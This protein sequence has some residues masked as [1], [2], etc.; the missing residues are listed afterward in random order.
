M[1]PM[2]T[3]GGIQPNDIKVVDDTQSAVINTQAIT[4]VITEEYDQYKVIPDTKPIARMN[5]ELKSPLYGAQHITKIASNNKPLIITSLR[6]I[7]SATKPHGM[8]DIIIP[9]K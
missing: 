3:N 2:K 4:K 6:P 7:V 8:A 9:L 5:E 1:V